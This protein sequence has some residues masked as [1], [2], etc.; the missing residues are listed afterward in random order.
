MLRRAY[1]KGP[2]RDDWDR[3]M[4]LYDQWGIPMVHGALVTSYRTPGAAPRPDKDW[5]LLDP[6]DPLFPYDVNTNITHVRAD[7]VFP[8]DRKP[9]FGDVVVVATGSY[10]AKDAK[11]PG[12]RTWGVTWINVDPAALAD[13]AA[14]RIHHYAPYK[15][16]AAGVI[17][18]VARLGSSS[19][20]TEREAMAKGREMRRLAYAVGIT[21]QAATAWQAVVGER[22]QV[23]PLLD[24][25]TS[26][27]WRIG[28]FHRTGYALAPAVAE[29]LVDQL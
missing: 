6:A 15:T 4:Q 25:T 16:I 19:A 20:N 3:S 29:R 26:G 21:R 24:E 28:G 17:D 5:R 12:R 11:L 8:A 27:V 22:L 2:E 13:P 14:L 1:H 23:T 10:G 9:I 18:G 7:A